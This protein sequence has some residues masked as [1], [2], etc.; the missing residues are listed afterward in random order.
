MPLADLTQTDLRDASRMPSALKRALQER[1]YYVN[2]RACADHSRA[3]TKDIGIVV[4][5]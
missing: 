1:I 3:H 5:A 2:C 4:L